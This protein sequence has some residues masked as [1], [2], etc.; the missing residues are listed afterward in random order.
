MKTLALCAALFVLGGCSIERRV[1]AGMA[2]VFDRPLWNTTQSGT[3]Y[4]DLPHQSDPAIQ[5][6]RHRLWEKVHRERYWHTFRN[7]P[8]VW[9]CYT[10]RYEAW[11]WERLNREMRAGRA[12]V[13]PTGM[14]YDYVP[15]KAWRRWQIEAQDRR[16][17]NAAKTPQ[18]WR[19][20]HGRVPRPM[21]GQP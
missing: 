4:W 18:W 21:G 8:W 14:G 15:D 5:R 11:S 20:N 7:M 10:T 6:R 19:D 17:F 9:N 16:R 13:S 3:S 2:D 1:A 12:R